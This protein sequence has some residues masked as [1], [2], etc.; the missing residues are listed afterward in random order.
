MAVKDS[1]HFSS[2]SVLDRND[3]SC[4]AGRALALGESHVGQHFS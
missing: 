2:F 4:L 1:H 3:N